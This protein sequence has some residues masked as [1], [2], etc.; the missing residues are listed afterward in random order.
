MADSFDP[1]QTV[2]KRLDC[3]ER[4]GVHFLA[5]IQQSKMQPKLLVQRLR[6]VA[7]NLQTAALAW[8]F[9]SEGTDDHISSGL[10]CAGNLADVG[11]TVARRGKEMKDSAVVPH[12]VSREIQFD[13]S[14]VG[15]EP[16]DTLRGS[17]QSFPVRIDGGLRNIEDVDGLVSTGEKVI[18]QGGFTAADVDDRGGATNSRLLYQGE[19]GLKVWYQLTAPGA[20]S[21]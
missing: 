15:D 20:F 14:D 1:A 16:M 5:A 9:R 2:K 13:L 11:D 10:H 8:P 6:I 21:V 3:A 17:S 7:N 12:I 19:R 18:D 4:C